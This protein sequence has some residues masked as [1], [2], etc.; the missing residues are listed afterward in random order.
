MIKLHHKTFRTSCFKLNLIDFAHVR[1]EKGIG[2]DEGVL[3]GI[4]VVIDA[5]ESFLENL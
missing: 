4:Q 3:K 5:F 2:P 1:F